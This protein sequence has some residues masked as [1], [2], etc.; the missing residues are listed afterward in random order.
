MVKMDFTYTKSTL[1]ITLNGI[2]NKKDIITLKRKMYYIV[3]EYEIDNIVLDIKNIK[4]MDYDAFYD[5]LDNYDIKYQG[6]LEVI[7]N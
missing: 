1:F 6:H 2:I 4:N 5:F 3:D 7:E